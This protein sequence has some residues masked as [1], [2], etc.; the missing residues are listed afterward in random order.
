MTAIKIKILAPIAVDTAG[1]VQTFHS[2]VIGRT[3]TY[4]K[5][6]SR[7]ILPDLV[8]KTSE[9]GT[10][11]IYYLQGVEFNTLKP[12]QNGRHF[13]DDTFRL[14][15]LNLNVKILTKISLKFVPKGPINNIWFK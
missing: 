13:A 4:K 8:R 14:I 5:R 9:C 10:K 11:I 7:K 15:F 2:P 1:A 12:R 3:F 6:L